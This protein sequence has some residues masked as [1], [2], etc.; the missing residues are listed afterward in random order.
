MVPELS[1]IAGAGVKGYAVELW[2]GLLAPPNMPR[3]LAAA[4]NA[5]VNKALAAQDMKDI[6]AR[7]GTEPWAQS[8]TEFATVVKTD[9]DAWKKVARDA[10]IKA[11]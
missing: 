4:I 3:E 1:A 9:I 6:L 5:E 11:E 10:N 2:W 8:S 7:E